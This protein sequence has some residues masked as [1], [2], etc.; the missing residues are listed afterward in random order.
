M[1]HRRN[2]KWPL[3]CNASTDPLHVWFQVGF[4]GTAHR[5]AHF[6][7]DQIQDGAVGHLDK[8]RRAKSLKCIIALS[9]LLYV[10]VY[11]A[12]VHKP[13]FALGLYSIMTDIRNLFHKGG[14]LADLPYTEKERKSRSW[15]IVLQKITR[16]EYTL[17]WS[18]SKVFLVVTM[19]WW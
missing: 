15:K 9:N 5:T 19:E 18:E 17:D 13:Y 12:Y 7:L 6:R 14:S 16:E 2:F 11:E 1:A 8:L 10:H 4:S 3:L